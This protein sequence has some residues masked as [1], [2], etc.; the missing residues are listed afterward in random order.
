MKLGRMADSHFWRKLAEKFHRLQRFRVSVWWI[1]REDGLHWVIEGTGWAE[2]EFTALATEAGAALADNRKPPKWPLCWI[3][4][5]EVKKN[6]HE[7]EFVSARPLS[8]C[9]PRIARESAI[10]CRLLQV[11]ARENDAESQ[12]MSSVKEPGRRHQ[13]YKVIDAALQKVAESRPDTQEEVFKSLDARNV[14]IPLLEPFM[15]ARGWIAGFRRDPP[16]ARAWLS[17]RWTG[18]KLPRLPRGPK[19]RKK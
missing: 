4:L 16:A 17:K 18:L 6:P 12:G 19:N 8:Y 10:L 13:K 5:N 3:W 9:I 7:S 15:A 11:R 1:E 14:A 2:A